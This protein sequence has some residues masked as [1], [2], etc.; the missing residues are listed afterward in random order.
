MSN[1]RGFRYKER[2]FGNLAAWPLYTEE[3]EVPDGSIVSVVYTVGTYQ[4]SSGPVLSSNLISVILI[5]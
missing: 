3:S 5:S 4:G 2:D 1:G